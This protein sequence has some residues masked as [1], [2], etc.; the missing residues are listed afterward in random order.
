MNFILIIIAIMA[1]SIFLID[2][3][4]RYF[5]IALKRSSLILCAVMAFV[6]NG[7]AI[8]LSPFLDHAHYFRLGGLVI[9]AAGIV[10]LFNERLLRRETAQAASTDA[11]QEPVPAGEA[12]AVHTP[13]PV[14]VPEP[15]LDVKSVPETAPEPEKQPEPLE[16][17]PKLV[18]LLKP[19]D[20]S[21]EVQ[22]PVVVQ[23]PEPKP[24][25][26][27]KDKPAPVTLAP[28]V[29]HLD[30]PDLAVQE[31]VKGLSTL[32]D[33][34]DLAYAE[35]VPANAAFIYQQAIARYA[36]DDYAPFLV[37]ELAT[38]YKDNAAYGDAIRAYE[39]GL[40]MPIIVDNDA[41]A[42]KFQETIGYLRTVQSILAKHHAEATKFPDIPGELLLEIDKASQQAQ[43]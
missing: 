11:A 42:A 1:V 13:E 38:L 10:T 8:T 39:R 30:K 15:I 7:L 33:L 17:K 28:T 22:E 25:P 2:H 27:P 37:I 16:A 41:M 40:H 4:C 12:E 19:K 43:A 20:K 14:S 36:D 23:K 29:I 32:D 24:A 6:V 31:Q 9:I 3:L 26:K 5:H 34:L 35:P 18:H 21:A